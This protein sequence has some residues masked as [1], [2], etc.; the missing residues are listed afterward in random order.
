MKP[1]PEVYT[2]NG[3]IALG[4]YLGERARADALVKALEYVREQLLL[5]G[6]HRPNELILFI[7]SMVGYE[8]ENDNQTD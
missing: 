8:E 6:Y 2:V 7:D 5:E 3:N 4:V 1:R